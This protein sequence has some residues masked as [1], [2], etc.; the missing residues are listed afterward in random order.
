[1]THLNFD[2]NY[3][4]LVLDFTGLRSQSHTTAITSDASHKYGVPGKPILLSNLATNQEFPWFHLQVP[5][6]ARLAHRTQESVANSPRCNCISLS[7]VSFI[8]VVQLYSV[9][10]SLQPH[11]LYHAILSCPSSWS[12]LKQM[13]IESVMSSNHLHLCCPLLLLHSIFPCIRV[14]S[15]ESALPSRW[16]KYWSFCFISVLPVNIQG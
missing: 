8:A 2:T 4:K 14:F 3:L 5:K 9:P 6:F 10:N 16:P 12:L 1:M 7:M 15:K 11:G 13:S